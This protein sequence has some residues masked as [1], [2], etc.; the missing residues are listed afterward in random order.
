MIYWGLLLF[1]ILEY[2]RPTSYI[3][4]L[5]PLK[6]N[7]LVPLGNFAGTVFTRGATAGRTIFTEPN[8]WLILFLLFLVQVSVLTADVTLYAYTGFTTLLGYAMAYWVMMSELT[9]V[10]R[11]KGLF[12]ALVFVHLVIAALNPSIFLEP[13]TRQYLASGFFLGDGNDFALSINIVIPLC[14]CLLL[15]TKRVLAKMV[16]AGALLILVACVILTQSRGGTIALASMALYYWF[17]SDKKVQTAGLAVGL[18]A[19][20]LLLAPPAYFE[21]MNMIADTQ[22]GS[23]SARLEAWKVGV[24]MAVDNPI[25]GVGAGHFGVKFGTTYLPRNISGPWMTAHS[26][27]FLALGE[28]GF[29]G[30]FF[31]V[32]FVV[33]NLLA[34]SRVTR[35]LL[36]AGYEGRETEYRIL[37][38]TSASLIA[39]AAG[40]AFLSCLYYPHIYVICGFMAA[41]RVVIRQRLGE[42]GS[43]VQ[44]AAARPREV[45]VHWALRRPTN[46]GLT[47]RGSR[48]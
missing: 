6:L 47:P 8:T 12:K 42:K 31:V 17:K 35:E 44:T 14:L 46:P 34:N 45:S 15:D 3:P 22:E 32:G 16:W 48:S 37:A 26:V 4:A 29:P 43:A 13:E 19:L 20:V 40:S 25:L 1:F 24:R 9:D 10:K 23:A 33:H 11:L 28:L 36:A 7:S 18:I 5:L 41:A 38:S 30:L 27:Y 39:F 21:R 2:V